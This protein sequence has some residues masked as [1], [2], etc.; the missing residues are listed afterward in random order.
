MASQLSG[1]LRLTDLD[2]YIAPSQECIKPVQIKKDD[3]QEKGRAKITIDS[4][5]DYLEMDGKTGQSKK[6]EKASITLAD[7]LACSGC[8]TSAESVL[9][10]EQSQDKL[11]QVLSS[12]SPATVVVT[13]SP[14]SR[15]SLA[16][17]FGL[18]AVDAGERLVA[19][20]KS[21]GVKYVFDETI[22]RD[23]SLL[24]SA[25]EFESRFTSTTSLPVLTSA[26]PGWIC[27]AEKTHGDFILPHVSS[28]KS[29]QQIL[30]SL[31]KERTARLLGISRKTIYHST[32]APCFDKK[33]EASRAEFADE[34]SNR[35][36]DCVL[37]SMEIETMLGDKSLAVFERIPYD[38]I[39]HLGDQQMEYHNHPGGGSGG[40]A[41][42]V[43]RR[44]A[45]RL[46]GINIS[47]DKPLEWR[48]LRNRDLR[49]LTLQVDGETKLKFAIAYGFRNIQN[50][51]QKMK[52]SRGGA[53]KASSGYHYVEIMACPAGCLNG[54]GQ[55]KDGGAT[56]SKELLDSVTAAYESIPSKTPGFDNIL[57][58]LYESWNEDDSMKLKHLHTS[59]RA[60]E[61]DITSL[62]IKW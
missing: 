41:D 26:C 47:P 7:C 33:L 14:Q 8:V 1:A 11:L 25:T 58:N 20:L 61:K 45:S 57:R 2:D 59:Y 5:G 18:T 32:I 55:I 62:N 24:E 34:D 51:V 46:F 52:R 16:A 48:T 30:G 38:S 31:V 37:T 4:A 50:L 44:S 15:S 6:L 23:I 39:L 43:F 53:A 42:F 22:G 10:T 9:I 13:V 3:K 17:R 28:V 56:A 54:G 49:E 35:D 60:V 36:V 12:G 21:L 29:P 27:Y 40:Y 19:F